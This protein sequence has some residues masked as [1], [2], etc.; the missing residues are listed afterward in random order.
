MQKRVKKKHEF[1]GLK[2]FG[3][4][5]CLGSIILITALLIAVFPGSQAT[6]V[7]ENPL[8][9]INNG[10]VSVN[11]DVL[12][13][14]EDGVKATLIVVKKTDS[15]GEV[16]PADT[17]DILNTVRLEPQQVVNGE[18]SIDFP[19][20]PSLQGVALRIFIVADDGVDSVFVDVEGAAAEEDVVMFAGSS[21][22]GV[23]VSGCV[24][25]FNPKKGTFI[26]LMN[27]D[28]EVDTFTTDIGNGSGQIEQSFE[29]QDV[30]PGT[31]SLIIT[32]Q[33]Y[34]SF[35]VNN[36]VVGSENV[37]LTQS[38]RADVRLMTLRCGDINE[39]GMIND[40]DLTL[41]WRKGNYDK[42]VGDASD[43][44]CDLN[45]DGMIND[46]DLTILWL[47]SNYNK[48][49]VV[50]DLTGS[51]N[52]NHTVTFKDW[53]GSVLD[54]QSVLHGSNAVPPIPPARSGYLFTGWDGSYYDITTD[55]VLTAIYTTQ[56]GMNIFS[57]TNAVGKPGDIVTLTVSLGGTVNTCGFDMRLIYD[58]DDLEYVSQNSDWDL[59]I[60]AF[61]AEE[62]HMIR[63]NYSATRNRTTAAKI[64]EVTFKIKNTDVTNTSVSILPVEIIFIDPEKDNE[65]TR[66]EN[67]QYCMVSGT[68]TINKN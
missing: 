64:M 30:V 45:G 1:G 65:P 61:H 20:D 37:D 50:I 13:A 8:A 28:V 16:P 59:D 67:D 57:V 7:F 5:C 68:V 43:P 33:A 22:V 56:D 51:S 15:T 25:S 62:E 34:T 26:Q 10:T 18:N 54:T 66:C 52:I 36:I 3:V 29:F 48:G 21:A 38:D 55:T 24:K 49:A 39:D 12:D 19:I 4:T 32:K 6:A 44:L 11:F 58:S 17:E 9:T 14:P 40:G 41:L 46:G 23:T 42:N 35:T 31:Y 60:V 53:D 63:F 47:V 2:I 27:G